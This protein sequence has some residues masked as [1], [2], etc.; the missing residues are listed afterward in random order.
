M[1][2]PKLFAPS[3]VGVVLLKWTAVLALGWVTHW[4]LRNSHAR[5][6]LILWRGMLCFGL[7]LPWVPL[8]PAPVFSI[9]IPIVHAPEISSADLPVAGGQAIQAPSSSTQSTAKRVEGTESI[10]VER[11]SRSRFLLV[12]WVVGGFCGAIRLIWFQIELSRLRNAAGLAG[13]ALQKLAHEIQAKLGVQGTVEIRI[14]GS[15]VSPFICGPLKPIIMLPETLARTLSS[16][17]LSALLAHEIAHFRQRDLIWCVGWRWMKTIWWFHPLV[18]NVPAAHNLACEEEADRIACAQFGDRGSYAQWLAQLALRVL[19]LPGVETGLALNGTAQIVQ[20]LNHLKLGGL[21][22]WKWWCSVVGI[23]ALGLFFFL[24]YGSTDEPVYHFKSVTQWLDS[25]AL[26]DEMRTM[27]K[28]GRNGYRL[29]YP[30][31][32]VTND[33]AVRALLAM[34]SR[35]VPALEKTLNEPPD[36]SLY[37]SPIDPTQRVKSWTVEKWRQL[38]GAGPDAPTPESLYFGS[39][40]QARMAAAGLAMLALGTNNNAGALRLLEIEA[41]A[42]SKGYQAPAL[43]AFNMANAG[44]PEQHKEIIAGIVA[45]LNDTNTRIQ[46]EACS[47]TQGFRT[48]LPEWKNKLMELAQ[49]PDAKVSLPL[50]MDTYVSQWALWS[51]ACAGR[52]DQEIVDLCEKAVQDKTRPPRLR[53][54]AA[55]G[56]GLAGDKAGQALPFL[57]AVATE[58]GIPKGSGLKGEARRAIDSIEKSIALRNA[59]EDSTATGR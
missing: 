39:F 21:R 12:I 4:L 51:L 53:S 33:P 24:I 58:Q 25:M 54:F 56:L 36:A 7:A 27:D 48:N 22:A 2:W 50:G 11:G 44:L 15:I 31:E 38:R 29:V 1:N 57:R 59:R 35:A 14:S 6:R 40:Q 37:P 23:A 32:V 52:K 3:P 28:D 16:V 42:R 8:L 30:P 49:G 17:E 41:A 45:G 19:A 46:L 13:P 20:R 9:A 18:W 26:F 5:W 47:A 10:P 43:Q 55:A 34:G